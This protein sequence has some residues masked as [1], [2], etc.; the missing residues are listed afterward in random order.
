MEEIRVIRLVTLDEYDRKDLDKL[1]RALYSAFGV[2][3][4]HSGSVKWPEDVG[5][6]VDARKLL[7]RVDSV[8]AYSDDKLL[9]LLSKKLKDRDLPSGA[10]PT[11]GFAKY[12]KERAIIST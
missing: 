7:E 11:Q 9:Y 4:E 6:P 10:V 3:C 1:C 2:G 5:D 8:R 12:G